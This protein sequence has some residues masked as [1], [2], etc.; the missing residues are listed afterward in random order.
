MKI[1]VICYHKIGVAPKEDPRPALFIKPLQFKLQMFLIKIFRY[2]TINPEELLKFIR[3]EK[4]SI[5]KPILITFDDGYKNNFTNAFP[6]LRRMG[7][8]ATIFICSG[9]IGK[10]NAIFENEKV[11]EGKMPED[12]LD[13]EDI[14]IMSENG[15]S[16]GSH[17]VNHYYL[18]KIEAQNLENEIVLSKQ[19]LEKLINKKIHFFSY[20]YGRYNDATI[21]SLKEAGYLGAFT[22][23]R[24]KIGKGDNPYE[25]KRLV[26]K[27]Y[28]RKFNF[29]ST[30]EFLYKLFFC[31]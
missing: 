30:F 12:Y 9:F 10:E 22:I 16:F 28:N 6:I 26:I 13:E 17:S 5:K 20:P 3:G 23:K 4:I 31:N 8:S 15:I 25:L 27:G 2:K 29:L 14:L 21:D 11:I 18:D 19:N 7:L 1:P 24:G